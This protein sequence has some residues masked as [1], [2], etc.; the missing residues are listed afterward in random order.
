MIRIFLVGS[1][2]VASCVTAHT[3]AIEHW[4]CQERIGDKQY[5]QQWTLADNRMF[6]PKG[7][8]SMPL[9]YNSDQVAV[10]YLLSQKNGQAISYIF[11]FDKN[12]GK[13]IEYD[14]L[15]AAVNKGAYGEVEPGVQ[16][17]PC[18]RFD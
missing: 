18:K 17:A 5:E 13:I 16:I 3:A 9:I 14:D 12:A 4:I 1:T 6:A 15:L 7:K 10:A 8:G 2:I 11:V